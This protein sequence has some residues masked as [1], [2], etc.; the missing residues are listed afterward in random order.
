MRNRWSSDRD[1][2][3]SGAVAAPR[4]QG[5]PQGQ[6]RRARPRTQRSDSWMQIQ[7]NPAGYS[8]EGA[9]HWVDA[10]AAVSIYFSVQSS[11]EQDAGVA[12][13]ID[14]MNMQR[15]RIRRVDRR[16]R[17]HVVWYRDRRR[18]VHRSLGHECER[19]RLGAERTKK[20]RVARDVTS[21]GSIEEPSFERHA[22]PAGVGAVG[23][24][25]LEVF[26]TVKVACA[27]LT[28]RRRVVVQTAAGEAH[29]HHPKRAHQVPS[30]PLSSSPLSPSEARPPIR[31]PI[32]RPR[33][34]PPPMASQRPCPFHRKARLAW[35]A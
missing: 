16:R 5:A 1:V 21:T 9:S 34:T 25:A 17:R 32:P 27:R 15:T 24:D 2:R 18:H 3:H 29:H 30:F 22:D 33:P 11:T 20:R 31:R 23:R 13:G 7:P 14:A 6:P 8:F 10:A 19:C 28:G 12:H 35:S 4:A 26:R